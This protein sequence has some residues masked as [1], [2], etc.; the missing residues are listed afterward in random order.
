MVEKNLLRHLATNND[1]AYL[2]AYAL[3]TH[4]RLEKKRRKVHRKKP[5]RK[6]RKQP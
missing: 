3:L 2:H 5:R 1:D 6:P 4:F